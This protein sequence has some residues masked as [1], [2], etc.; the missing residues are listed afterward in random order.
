[1]TQNLTVARLAAYNVVF[2]MTRCG[3]LP[4][5]PN[6]TCV[7][8]NP[9]AATYSQLIAQSLQCDYTPPTTTTTTSTTTATTTSTTTTTT[10]TTTTTTTTTTTVAGLGPGASSSSGGGGSIVP[11]AAAAAGGGGVLLLIVI[12]LL[13]RRSKAT[14]VKP[15]NKQDDRTVV[16]FE[17]PMYD[18]PAVAQP[19]MYEPAPH[20]SE[21]LYDSPALSQF[22]SGSASV[23]KSNPLYNSAENLAEENNM[24]DA[25]MDVAPSGRGAAD[26]GYMESAAPVAIDATGFVNY[27]DNCEDDP[28]FN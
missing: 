4:F 17:N 26:V 25:Y 21:G 15:K 27:S 12:V 24:P 18:D 13:V 20:D 10:S 1:M 16:A 3:I 14:R 23:V 8:S 5:Y 19:S 9:S 11:V 2:N 6:G 28:T 22:G 7:T